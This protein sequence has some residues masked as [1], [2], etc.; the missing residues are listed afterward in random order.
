MQKRDF[1]T[2]RNSNLHILFFDRPFKELCWWVIYLLKFSFFHTS[3]TLFLFVRKYLLKKKASF[4]RGSKFNKKFYA[5]SDKP[6]FEIQIKNNTRDCNI[7][8]ENEEIKFNFL[9]DKEFFVFGIA[10]LIEPYNQKNINGW[11]LEIFLVKKDE[12]LEKFV[13]NLPFNEANRTSSYVYAADDG[14][15]DL[16]LDLSKYKNVELDIKLTAS[17][18]RAKES[19]YIEDFALSFPQFI[20]KN[21]RPKNIILLSIESLSDFEFLSKEYKVDNL[22]NIN[23]LID[24]SNVYHDVIS[25]VDATLTYAASMISGLLPSQHGIGDYSIG[26]DA[27]NNK[28]LNEKLMTLPRKLKEEG[29]LNFFLGTAGRFSSKIG[30]ADGFDDHF[31]VNSNFDMNRPSINTLINGL[32]SFKQ[33]NKFFF[34]H[35][36]HLH[37]PFLSFGNETKPSLQNINML[38]QD[39]PEINSDLYS[40]GLYKLDRDIGILTN[41]LKENG[42]YN[43][44]FIILTGDHGNGINWIKGDEYSLYEER[45]KVPLIV[46]YPS[47]FEYTDEDLEGSVNSIFKI[48]QLINNCLGK[49]FN[50]DLKSLPQYS[51]DFKNFTFGE[52]IMMPRKERNRHCLAVIYQNYKYVC[53]NL[54]DWDNFTYLSL[55]DEKIFKRPTKHSNFDESINIL[56]EVNS[57]DL[58]LLKKAAEQVIQKNLDFMKKYPPQTF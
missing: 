3:N 38:Q 1:Y 42:Q 11:T 13:I 25:P 20:E 8:R 52:T 56:K 39:N 23:E 45:L 37:E 9:G 33:F 18:V 17:L 21:S 28:T 57:S 35:L 2:K 30:F 15:V 58:A 55:L 40:K 7:F 31:Q 5:K 24:H 10:P 4:A 36:D 29:Y 49:D 14:W 16:K 47:W 12:L 26:S 46:K 22:K 41:Y 27:F 6:F 48:H 44:T 19:R 50:E 34:F 54:V 43:D 32:D 53:W 51:S